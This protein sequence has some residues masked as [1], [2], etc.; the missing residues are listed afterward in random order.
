MSKAVECI[1][2]NQNFDLFNR[3]PLV[4]R[5][6]DSVCMMCLMKNIG[7]SLYRCPFCYCDSTLTFALVK[8][9][10]IN[11]ALL[12]YI[13]EKMTNNSNHE[14]L[15]SSWEKKFIGSIFQTDIDEKIDPFIK[16]PIDNKCKR[17]D[18]A[19]EKYCFNNVIYEYCSIDCY[20]IDKPEEFQEKLSN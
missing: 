20:Q 8:D 17:E 19:K 7:L 5:C 10:P 4:L 15:S 6:G 16:T 13:K 18:C 9:M 1:D 14:N 3:V 2:C 12:D 11:K